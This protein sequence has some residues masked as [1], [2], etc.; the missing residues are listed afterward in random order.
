M[1]DGEGASA[2]AAPAPAEA[3]EDRRLAEVR[4][5][6][7]RNHVVGLSFSGGG[8]RSGTFAVGFIQGLAQVGLLRRVDY[9]STVSG[10]GYAGAWLA[11]WLKRDGNPLNVEHQLNPNRVVQAKAER[12]LLTPPGPGQTESL[13]RVVDEEPAP[14]HHL[15]QYS[16]YLT[17]RPGLLTADTWTVIAIWLRNVSVNLVMMLLPL[18]MILVL[19]ARTIIYLYSYVSPTAINGDAAAYWACGVLL[20]VGLVLLGL[21]FYRNAEALGEF[22]EVKVVGQYRTGD[23]KKRPRVAVVLRR[24]VLA[25][26]VVAVVFLTIPL[27]GVIWGLGVLFGGATGGPRLSDSNILHAVVDYVNANLGLLDPPNLVLHG[28]ILGA[29]MGVCALIVSAWNGIPLKGSAEDSGGLWKYASSAFIAGFSAGV[30]IPLL[31]VLTRYLNDVGR[32]ELAATLIPPLALLIVVAGLF[33]EV[34]LLGRSITEAEREWWSRLSALLL[35]AS[36]L[37]TVAL[38]SIVYVP[39]ALLASGPVLRTALASG[40]LATTAFGVLSGRRAQ[41]K[42]GNGDLLGTIAAVV[43]PIFLV[44]FLGAAS[45]FAA[46]L[47]NMP[48]LTFP[49]AN[50]DWTAVGRYFQGVRGASF[51]SMIGWLIALAFLFWL[52]MKQIDVNLFSL[53]AM[54][55]NRLVRCYLGASRPRIRWAE[56]WGDIHDTSAGGGASSLSDSGA[57]LSAVDREKLKGLHEAALAIVPGTPYDAKRLAENVRK[58]REVSIEIV[59]QAVDQL[60]RDANPETGFDPCDDIPL[61]DLGIGRTLSKRTYWGPQLLINTT[62][63]LVAGEDLAWQD[64][65]GESFVLTPRYCGSKG[66]GYAR[67]TEKTREN[68][69]L[70]RAITIS[71]AAVDPNM[72]F[73][74]SSSLTAFLTI[75]NARLGQWMQNPRFPQWKAEGPKFGDRLVSELF[76]STD[77]KDAF[78][79]LT[80]GGHFENLGVYELI[81]RRCRYII[82]VDA[83]EDTDA[84]DDNLAQLTRLCRIDFGVRIELDTDPLEPVK[85]NV[86]SRTHVVVGRVHYEDV[87]SGQVP[88]I[89]VYIKISMTGDEPSDVLKYAKRDPRFPHQPTDLRQSFTDEQ[90]ESYRALGDHIARDVFSDTVRRVR[91]ERTWNEPADLEDYIRGNQRL[92]SSLRS[93]WATAPADHDA[94]YI[95]V[96]RGVDP[97]PARHPQGTR[98]GHVESG[99]LPRAVRRHGE[100]PGQRLRI[101]PP[102]RRAARGLADDPA[103]GERLDQPPPQGAQRPPHGPRLDERLPPL[104]RHESVPPPLAHYEVGV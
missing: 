84:S 40:W 60:V 89:I 54:Y 6:A 14:L 48:P 80:D 86:F 78:I 46:H 15:R 97:I 92:F 96:G 85:P 74:Q 38:V 13:S 1:A 87:D 59:K 24:Q 34:A 31:E 12:A 36:L 50:Q 19:I 99:P 47:V 37:W 18:T 17:P 70:G 83:G 65:K 41:P 57:P 81:R 71:G 61:F 25:P 76:G 104:D 91:D 100:G 22:R 7:L 9:L 69:T 11:A 51:W 66:V 98:A 90:F 8:I 64:R 68:L 53:H 93:R 43:P 4:L 27:R 3:D 101:I 52:G 29:I 102:T 10:G 77:D 45:L 67:M 82:A 33:V 73:Y 42:G 75:F 56:R 63:N 79:H 95:A 16:S 49:D 44:G 32:P 5:E 28:V 72:S 23:T 88:G 103:H 94:R 21:A 58:R 35:I 26:L 20:A 39:A 2:L 30:L 55:A 62:L